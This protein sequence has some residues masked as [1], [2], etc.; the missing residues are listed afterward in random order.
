MQL[1]LFENHNLL[2]NKFTSKYNLS[3]DNLKDVVVFITKLMKEYKANNYTEIKDLLLEMSAY[4]GDSILKSYAGQWIWDD[5]G[6]NCLLEINKTTRKLI[7]TPLHNIIS[8]WEGIDEAEEYLLQ[9]YEDLESI[10]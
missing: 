9:L 7:W 6:K 2:N 5:K 3:I 1:Y 10:D 8:S 4:Y